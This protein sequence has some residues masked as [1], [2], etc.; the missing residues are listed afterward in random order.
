[1]GLK[2]SKVSLKMAGM[3]SDLTEAEQAKRYLK[4]KFRFFRQKDIAFVMPDGRR[5]E[6]AR[7]SNKNAIAAA[8][9]VKRQE[10]L[11]ERQK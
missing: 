3:K 7:I 8:A 6:L 4:E 11:L 9:M 1:L 2:F 5:I 10:A